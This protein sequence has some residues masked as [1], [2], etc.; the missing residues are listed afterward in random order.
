MQF[1]FKSEKLYK[2]FFQIWKIVQVK[3][4]SFYYIT[5]E[6][7]GIFFFKSENKNFTVRIFIYR[8]CEGGPSWDVHNG[9]ATPDN[10][11]RFRL[12]GLRPYTVYSFRVLAVN[13]MGQSN[14]SQASYCMVTL[15][16]GE[17]SYCM[18]TLREGENRD[19]LRFFFFEI[20]FSRF[21][22]SSFFF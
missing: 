20:F 7:I 12:Q 10:A 13:A 16:E 8:F 9:H 15:R 11:T 1:F 5:V 19:F 14:P 21:F 18:V 3:L 4:M 6:T 17:S 2:S 22:F